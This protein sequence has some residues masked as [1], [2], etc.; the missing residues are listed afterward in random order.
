MQVSCTE[1]RLSDD[2]VKRVINKIRDEKEIVRCHVRT[3][4]RTTVQ[5]IDRNA[6]LTVSGPVSDAACTVYYCTHIL[7]SSTRASLTRMVRRML[8]YQLIFTCCRYS[9][10]N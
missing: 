3:T 7:Y 1:I 10:N 2:G 4:R 9:I 5:T 8:S 6:H